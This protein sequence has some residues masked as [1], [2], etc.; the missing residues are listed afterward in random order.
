MIFPIDSV[1]TIDI[2]VS[3]TF[4]ALEAHLMVP[5]T[6]E[7]HVLAAQGFTTNHASLAPLVS[8]V[9]AD[10]SALSV[11]EVSMKFFPASAARKATRV[12]KSI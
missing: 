2:Q 3:I 11:D 7:G 12:P 4:G 6:L 9:L 5:L 10:R 8:T 1:E